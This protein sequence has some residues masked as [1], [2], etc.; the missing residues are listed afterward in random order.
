[1]PTYSDMEY[2]Q[3][4][5]DDNWSWQE[6]DYL[7]TFVFALLK[8]WSLE[9]VRRT[10]VATSLHHRRTKTC[11]RCDTA[12]CYMNKHMLSL[13][14]SVLDKIDRW[15]SPSSSN[16]D[17]L[18]LVLASLLLCVVSR[19]IHVCPLTANLQASLI[20]LIWFF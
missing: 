14:L 2:Q 15:R 17:K 10:N 13:T 20:L 18:C 1:M 12:K 6:T 16:S 11:E 9:I 7:F 4:L 19:R 8:F 3:H 5:H